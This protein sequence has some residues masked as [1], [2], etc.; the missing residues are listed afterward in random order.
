MLVLCIADP[1]GNFLELMQVIMGAQYAG[2]NPASLVKEAAQGH[3]DNVRRILSQH[4]QQV[5]DSFPLSFKFWHSAED[6]RIW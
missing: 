3:T 1:L 4:P 2:L 5:F 6:T